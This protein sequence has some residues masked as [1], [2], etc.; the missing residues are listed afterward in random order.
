MLL[1]D[2]LLQQAGQQNYDGTSRTQKHDHE[3]R[4]PDELRLWL[5]FL[6]YMAT[7]P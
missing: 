4:R 6:R 1:L 3:T 5:Q 7:V 2:G